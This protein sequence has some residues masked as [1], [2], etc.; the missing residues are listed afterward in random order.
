MVVGVNNTFRGAEPTW[1]NACVGN[2]GNPSYVEYSK[3]FS[4]AANVLI[5]V[6]LQGRG[7]EFN[8]DDLI[9][10]VCFNMRHSV[11][12][13]LKGA[14][15]E[16]DDIV[17]KRGGSVEFDF[18][19]SHDLGKIWGFFKAASESL[20]YR[21]RSINK[22]IEPTIEDIANI[23]A[24]G[25]TFRYPV[26]NESQ[27]HLTDVSLINFCVLLREFSEL[28]KNLDRLHEISMYLCEEYGCGTYT[29]KLNRAQIY[30]IARQ[31]P[32]KP[33]WAAGALDVVKL[34]VQ[35]EY[36][37]SSND[38]G[39]VLN[40]IKEHHYLSTLIGDPVPLL[41][42]SDA[43]VLAYFDHWV[44]RHPIDNE[45]PDFEVFDFS[46]ESAEKMF[47]D[48]A[49]S[50]RVWAEVWGEISKSLTPEVVAGLRSLF[51]FARDR[52]YVE[53]YKVIYDYEL[54][55]QKLPGEME[56]GFKH[57]FDKTNG[58]ENVIIS[59]FALGRVELA[60]ALLAKHRPNYSSI[61]DARSGAL[62]AYPDY[63]DY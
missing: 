28:E 26:S 58:L 35:T 5:K 11:E 2:N 36:G 50:A 47:A 10:P 27:K 55:E 62:F 63:A 30:K 6:V 17:K 44:K 41:G 57:L 12:L 13:R 3:G 15:E 25:Q 45:A 49:F 53:Y 21:F 40:K 9:Y 42:V 54:E 61:E 18:S 22:L 59:L 34:K 38:F 8:V 29:S 31:L 16:L 24:T 48:M 51:Y 23:D 32:P 46:E 19:T 60:E 43:Q 20:D 37:L 56:R 4:Q 52:R 7:L 39:R 14:I 1:A 33:T